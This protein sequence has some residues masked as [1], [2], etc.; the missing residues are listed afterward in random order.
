MGE[1][2]VGGLR[3]QSGNK[4]RTWF[5]RGVN[6]DLRGL[7]AAALSCVRGANDTPLAQGC[8]CET[9]RL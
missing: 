5:Y 8:C 7:D 2:L 1:E 4:R 9:F 3:R 6:I